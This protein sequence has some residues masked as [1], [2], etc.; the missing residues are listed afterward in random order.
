MEKR[1][2]LDGGRGRFKV[3]GERAS[4]VEHKGTGWENKG[5]LVSIAYLISVAV[6]CVFKSLLISF[7]KLE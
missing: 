1:R 4:L 6:D 3:R 7:G 2:C 5:G